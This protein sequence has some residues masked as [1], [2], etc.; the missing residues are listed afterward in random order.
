MQ[1]RLHGIHIPYDAD[2]ESRLRKEAARRLDLS[3][4]RLP[5]YRVARR[6]V[7]ARKRPVQFVYAVDIAV[8]DEFDLSSVPDAKESPSPVP[9]RV[10]TGQ[11]P[12]SSP[13][14]VIGGG[15][16]GLFATLLLA[17][18]GF[19]PILIERG[20]TSADRVTALRRFADT[21]VPDPECN[22]LFGIGGAG[23]FSDGKLSTGVNH[24]W[25]KNVLEILVTCGAPA[26]ILFDAKPHVGTDILQDTVTRLVARIE[27]AGGEVRPHTRVDGFETANRR[28]SGLQTSAGFVPCNAAVV[29]V[30]H[31]SRDTWQALQAA[32]VM[33][34]PKPFQLGIRAEHPQA[35]LD[36]HR[37]GKA[38]GHPALGAADYKLATQVN[39]TPVFSFCMCPGGETMPT[40]NEP[41]HLAINGM[42]ESLRES[43]FSSSGL[44]VTL[45]P[46]TYGGIDLDSCLA[47]Q[48]S[49]EAACFRAGGENYAAPAQRLIDFYK[50]VRSDTPPETSFR[51]GVRSAD[52]TKVLPASVA[53]PLRSALAHFDRRIPGYLHPEAAALAPESRASSPVRIVRDART[54]ASISVEGIFPAGEGAGYAGGIMSS[55]LD[56]LN[57]ACKIAES[58]HPLY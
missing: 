40:V 8:P 36:A 23:T 13:P 58:Y 48:R 47:F 51:L 33:I 43:P 29:A 30:G 39:G 28:L 21:R 4:D 25:L 32:G 55:A 54:L 7:D 35:W 18:H 50:G 9:M 56:G 27:A 38:A 45:T 3:E 57:A 34:S 42:S 49:V 1:L 14:V 19:R 11:T 24:P 10:E 16:A 41:N 6:S 12:M 22:A 44:V 37:Y 17:E 20:G 26:Q 53:A 2:Q 31:S 5:P 15:P 46:E 52:L